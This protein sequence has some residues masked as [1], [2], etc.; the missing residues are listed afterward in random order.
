MFMRKNRWSTLQN[1]HFP[2]LY[3]DQL[4]IFNQGMSKDQLGAMKIDFEIRPDWVQE[5]KTTIK[6]FSD[7]KFIWV[8]PDER[9]LR[10]DMNN[11]TYDTYENIRRNICR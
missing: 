2:I 10:L 6:E 7:V 3:E 8:E 11:L 5:M 1:H 9:T 4:N